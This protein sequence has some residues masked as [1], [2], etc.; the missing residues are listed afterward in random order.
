[1]MRTLLRVAAGTAAAALV[2]LATPA[3]AQEITLAFGSAV[4]SIDPLFHNLSSN[5]NISLNIFDRLIEQDERQHLKPG[6]ATAWRP[7]DDTTWEFTL[8]PGVRFH[9]GSDFSAE[10]V[11]ASLKRVAWM[12]NS[13]SPFTIYTRAIAGTVVVDAHTLHIKTATPYPLLPVDISSIHIVSR[14]YEQAPTNEFN[15]GRAAIGT[16]PFKFVQYVAGDRIVVARNDDYWGAKP[17]WQKAT[18]RIIP[19]NPTRIAALLAGDV[20]GIDAVPP[21]DL[22]RLQVDPNVSV[23]RTLSNTVLFLHMDQFRDQTPFATD[24]SGAPLPHNPIKDVRV[25]KAISKAMNRAALV[26]RVME[27]SAIPASDLLAQGFFGVSPRIKPDAFDPEGARK[28]LADAGYPNGFAV[29]IHGPND[30]Y[31][32]DEKVLQAIAPMLVR[33]GID[34]KVV[35]LPWSTFITQASAPNYAYSM[36]LIGNGATTGEYSFPVRAQFAT[37]DRDRGMGA[38]NRARYSNPQLDEVLAKALATVDDAKRELLLQQV[39]EI[40]MADQALVPLFHQDNLFATRK[41]LN[42]TA[43]A[44]GYMA[45]FMVRPAN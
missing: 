42:Y 24:R 18:L 32:N 4:T 9:D 2:A 23:A 40:A 25:R 37:V 14:K 27:S 33:V 45:A 35:A 30:R 6:L 1:M 15:D 10:D 7:I 8:R 44:D 38:S 3:A 20:Q 17:T 31:V 5:I 41:G 43:R 39:G 34:T 21:T 36:L 26:E 16:G 19:A 11:V 28:L 12:P 22:A 29:T 13:P